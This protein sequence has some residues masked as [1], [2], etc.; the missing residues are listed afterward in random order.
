MILS[1]QWKCVK[2]LTFKD[3]NEEIEK[4]DVKV[5]EIEHSFVI[6]SGDKIEDWMKK[7]NPLEK[8]MG[9]YF[10][11]DTNIEEIISKKKN[12]NQKI[13]EETKSNP[14]KQNENKEEINLI[15][16]T[17]DSKKS[18]SKN[19]RINKIFC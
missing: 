2:K 4:A 16:E 13:E 7:G 6:I 10:D 1:F 14:K 18:N 8:G 9:Y 11:S 19:K 3:F 17:I 15:N 12:E 5:P